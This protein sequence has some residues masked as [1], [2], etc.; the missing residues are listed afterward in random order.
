MAFFINLFTQETWRE[1]RV[2]ARWEFTGHTD[3]LRNRDRIDRGDV[4]LCWSIRTSAF[5]GALEVT[6]ESYE[7]RDEDPPTWQSQP[8][9]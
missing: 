3:R 1:I 8:F 9:R 7:E 4:F 2:N 5:A 6:G